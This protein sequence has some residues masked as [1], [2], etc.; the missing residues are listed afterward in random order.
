M[1]D[2]Q[3]KLTQLETAEVAVVDEGEALGNSKAGRRK[4]A[5]KLHGCP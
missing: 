3:F 1:S 2:K 5:G 4:I